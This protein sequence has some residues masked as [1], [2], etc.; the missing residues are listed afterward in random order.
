MKFSLRWNFIPG[1]I[2]FMLHEHLN[3]VE[4][5]YNIST[6]T[7]IKNTIYSML[8]IMIYKRKLLLNKS[9]EILKMERQK[10]MEKIVLALSSALRTCLLLLQC[11]SILALKIMQV[12]SQLSITCWKQ[13]C[14]E[15]TP[16]LGSKEWSS[17]KLWVCLLINITNKCAFV[18]K[19]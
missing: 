3:R 6:R 4:N 7:E 17:V 9:W 5:I 18:Q 13:Y 16:L 2:F 11:Y 10:N 14:R 8:Y 19:I 1:W 12:M 15:T